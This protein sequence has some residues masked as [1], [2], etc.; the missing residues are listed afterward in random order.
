[1]ALVYALDK[2]SI[3]LIT[4]YFHSFKIFNQILLVSSQIIFKMLKKAN[5]FW[6]ILKH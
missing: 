1:M 2:V 3:E 5:A 4:I 6:M